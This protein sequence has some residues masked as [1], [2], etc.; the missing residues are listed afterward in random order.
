[1]ALDEFVLW[2]NANTPYKTVQDYVRAV[3]A[4]PAKT[5]KMGGAGSKREDEIVTAML[6]QVAGV[7]FMFIPYKGGGE[8][9]RSSSASTS[10]RTSTIRSS[11]SRTGAQVRCAPLCVF[12]DQRMPFNEQD[13]R[14]PVLARHSH[15]QGTRRRRRST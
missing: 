4:A 12:D 7:N 6:E 2:V 11:I 15:L 9:A 13:R 14:R 3:K 8:I 1:M 5:F 10:T